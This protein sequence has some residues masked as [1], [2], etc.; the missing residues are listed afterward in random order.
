[1]SNNHPS[2]VNCKKN[3]RSSEKIVATFNLISIHANV[4]HYGEQKK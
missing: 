3:P 1:M 4:G 2:H